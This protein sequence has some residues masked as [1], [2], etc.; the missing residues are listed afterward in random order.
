MKT[1][2]TRIGLIALLGT[3]QSGCAILD[4]ITPKLNPEAKI[5]SIKPPAT[6]QAALPHDGEISNLN[7]FWQRYPD[8]ILLEMISTAQENAPTLATA[9][10]NL[11]EARANRVRA[12]AIRLPMLD[13]NASATRA[14]QQ[15]KDME[16]SGNGAG[17]VQAGINEPTNT[18][19]AGLQATW[20]LD[21]YGANKMLTDAATIQENAAK[22]G[23]HEARVAVAAEVA[24]SYFNYLL[25]KQLSDTQN[26]I[27]RSNSES[28]RLSEIAFN[29]GFLDASKQTSAQA[30]AADAN[31]QARY[32]ALQCELEVKNLTALTYWPEQQVRTRLTEAQI[33]KPAIDLNKLFVIKEVPA[34]VLAQRPDVY[35]AEANLMSAAANV[36]SA[37]AERY[38]KVT[39][40]GSIGW[41]R[42][43]SNSFKS[44]G[45]VWS[46]GPV[47][48]TL[49]IFD[50]G[51]LKANQ[52]LAEARYAEA[53][54]K[55]RG[56]VQTAVKEVENALVNLHSSGERDADV[57]QALQSMYSNLT[58]IEAK[59]K[60]GF[61]NMIDV[62][63]AKRSLMQ[64]QKTALTLQQMRANAWLNLYR[65]AGGGW[66]H[67]MPIPDLET[68]EKTAVR[69]NQNADSSDATKKDSKEKLNVDQ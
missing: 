57:K 50:G 66:E 43:S 18:L 38:P 60:A 48:V 37:A 41:M 27:A 5:A 53:A 47:S 42:L 35:R 61:A 64:V 23:W 3:A 9:T 69:T 46:L 7:E 59:Q 21:L 45:R 2:M 32:Q 17:G 44:D 55:Y 20:E 26:A 31:Q 19:Q 25:C 30:N 28:A 22:A 8:P 14:L 56:T 33:N 29:A 65:A 51:K 4:G 36:K 6:W 68:S 54:A 1:Y 62:E 34:Q 13:G 10:A 67:T 40:N 63:D 24:T 52:D 58:S 11:A 49:P 12:N 16:F 15:P 39:L